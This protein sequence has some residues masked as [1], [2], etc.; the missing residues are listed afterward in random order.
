[1]VL[2]PNPIDAKGKTA[3]DWFEPSLDGRKSPSQ[4]R[5]AEA[6]TEHCIFTTPRRARSCGDTI[7]HVQ[8][9]TAGGSAAWNADGDGVYYTRFPAQRRAT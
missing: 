3:I 4:F 8:Y 9:P 5:R 1:M 2:D 7:A 6:K